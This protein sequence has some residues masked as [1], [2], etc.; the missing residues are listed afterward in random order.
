LKKALE[1]SP[2]SDEAYR[3]LGN[4]YADIGQKDRA[5]QALQNATDLNP[6]YWLNQRALGNAYFEFS[7]YDKAL[8]Q[9]QAVTQ[10]DQRMPPA[11]TML[12]LS[13]RAWDGTKRA[14][15]LTKSVAASAIYRN[16][17]E[18]GHGIFLFEEV[19]RSGADV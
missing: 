6:Y 13:I 15:R 12:G 7:D 8:K 3:R 14:S 19:S 10:L 11:T 17:L 9:Y 4:A 16:L 1:L 2:N 18:F 5:I